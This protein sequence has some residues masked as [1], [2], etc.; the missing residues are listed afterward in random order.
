[1]LGADPG[2]NGF[3]PYL[4]DDD[5]AAALWALSEELVGEPFVL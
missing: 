3:L 2:V 4:L 1:M 5:H